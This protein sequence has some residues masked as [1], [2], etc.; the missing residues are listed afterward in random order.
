MVKLALVTGVN[1]DQKQFGKERVPL[2]FQS[3]SPWFKKKS[4]RVPNKNMEA[5]TEMEATEE[6]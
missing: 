6:T 3:Y 4:A 2:I 5:E 1:M